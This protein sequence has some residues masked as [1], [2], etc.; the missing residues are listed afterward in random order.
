MKKTTLFSALLAGSLL[1]AGCGTPNQ[2]SQQGAIGNIL[3]NIATG[4]LTGQ[5]P[6]SAATGAITNGSAIS[7]II[8]ILTNGLG[9]S[10]SVSSIY[11]TWVYSEPAIQFES[12][13]ALSVSRRLAHCLSQ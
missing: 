1:L 9:S 8:G 3:G 5:D 4:V 12:E 6:N 2:Q 13:N 7:S 11:G 10:N